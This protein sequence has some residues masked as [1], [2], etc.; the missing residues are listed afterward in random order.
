M[1]KYSKFNHE[2]TYPEL[3]YIRN[4]HWTHLESFTP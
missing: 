3:P 1:I 4:H 2:V